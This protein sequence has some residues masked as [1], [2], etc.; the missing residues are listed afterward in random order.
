MANK[1]LLAKTAMENA[2]AEEKD[3]LT[4][5]YNALVSQQNILE[6][7]N[8][9][10]RAELDL[11]IAIAEIQRDHGIEELMTKEKN[12]QLEG[13]ALSML[14]KQAAAQRTLIILLKKELKE[15]HEQE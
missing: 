10:K 3:T 13:Q 4:D 15:K 11:A 9:L 8:N 14:E 12:L 6:D 2:S 7:N 1:V 5:S